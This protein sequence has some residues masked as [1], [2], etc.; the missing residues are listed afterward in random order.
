MIASSQDIAQRLEA[1]LRRVANCSAHHSGP[2]GG[3]PY[4]HLI[5]GHVRELAMIGAGFTSLPNRELNTS[6]SAT[7]REL[8]DLRKRAS[9]LLNSLEVLHR[10]ALDAL[11]IKPFAIGGLSTYLRL[12]V[13]S[14]DHAIIEDQPNG[15]GRGSKYKIGARR[16]TTYAIEIYQRLSGLKATIITPIEGGPPRGPFLDFLTEI[17]EVL[18][19]KAKPAGQAKMAL[20]G[21]KPG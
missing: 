18:E 19:I 4:E 15:A 12:I 16:V 11:C 6:T 8:A 2:L 10:P 14:V 9:A 7:Q 20:Y 13:S 21:K 17:F 3:I 5:P 1:A